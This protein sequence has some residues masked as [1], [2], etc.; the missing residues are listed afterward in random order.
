MQ[1]IGP[2]ICCRPW[3]SFQRKAVEL[4][5]A[6]LCPHPICR[7]AGCVEDLYILIGV[8]QSVLYIKKNIV[9]SFKHIMQNY[10]INF[11]LLSAQCSWKYDLCE[12]IDMLIQT[13]SCYAFEQIQLNSFIIAGKSLLASL[14]S[15]PAYCRVS[16]MLRLTD[17]LHVCKIRIS[18]KVILGLNV[19][20][21][22]CFCTA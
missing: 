22:L 10:R 19:C 21:E 11:A 15:M 12:S 17:W 2:L 1:V 14:P 20:Q 8:Y 6:C 9:P 4:A 3:A 16:F 13:T 5:A 7:N 18:R